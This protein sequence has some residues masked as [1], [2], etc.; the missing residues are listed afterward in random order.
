[1]LSSTDGARLPWVLSSVAIDGVTLQ[2]KEFTWASDDQPGTVPENVQRWELDGV[3]AYVSTYRDSADL[4]ELVLG[5]IS[6]EFL[7]RAMVRD[8]QKQEMRDLVRSA[9]A[10]E[11]RWSARALEVDGDVVAGVT[12]ISPATSLG[13]LTGTGALL[14]ECA[15]V[16]VHDGGPEGRVSVT[17]SA[18][19]SR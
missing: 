16:V 10:A 19:G 11:P 5:Q 6:G 18:P 7:S 1:M 12:V 8:L 14:N 15:V 3:R 4:E 17:T 13:V 2:R 9:R